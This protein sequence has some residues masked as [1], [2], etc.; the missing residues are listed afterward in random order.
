[1]AGSKGGPIRILRG[2]AEEIT[3]EVLHNTAHLTVLTPTQILRG[4]L[5]ASVLDLMQERSQG[6]F[7]RYV[8]LQP[9]SK[10]EIIGK[11]LD[12]CAEM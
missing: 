3:A 8:A 5:R 9:R 11:L 2:S 10:T 1:V 12:N 6:G 7:G 4:T